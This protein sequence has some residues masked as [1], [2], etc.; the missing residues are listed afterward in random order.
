L[1]AIFCISNSNAQ[2]GS[3]FHAFAFF[4]MPSEW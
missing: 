3:V 4:E 1:Q 2:A